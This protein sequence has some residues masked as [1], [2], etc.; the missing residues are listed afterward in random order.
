M[1]QWKIKKSCWNIQN[2]ICQSKIGN[3]I[4]LRNKKKWV[5]IENIN[6]KK[7]KNKKKKKIELDSFHL[8]NLSLKSISQ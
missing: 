5:A 4:L 2:I 1:K 7:I 6:E 3:E 8:G